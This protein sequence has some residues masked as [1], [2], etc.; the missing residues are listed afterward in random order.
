MAE[1][2]ILREH[3][4]KS[5]PDDPDIQRQALKENQQKR[6]EQLNE[7]LV[8]LRARRSEVINDTKPEEMSHDDL[9]RMNKAL[10]VCMILLSN[11]FLMPLFGP[12]WASI[13]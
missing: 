4:F 8:Y 13:R 1:L 7:T 11:M 12:Y 6:I 9:L 3:N 10:T 2:Q 5:L